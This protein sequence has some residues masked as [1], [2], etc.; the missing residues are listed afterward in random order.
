MLFCGFGL[1]CAVGGNVNRRMR[2]VFE[3]DKVGYLVARN[4]PDN[5]VDPGV[6][7][8][9][10][11]GFDGRLWQ[12]VNAGVTRRAA[13]ADTPIIF[14]STPGHREVLVEQTAIGRN[15]Q[16]VKQIAVLKINPINDPRF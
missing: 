5:G 8:K 6:G 12:V 11:D 13:G 1:D 4:L 16:W 2:L 3:S 10:L 15:N 9:A 14:G 7:G